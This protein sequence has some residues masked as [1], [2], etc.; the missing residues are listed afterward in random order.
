MHDTHGYLLQPFHDV[1]ASSE[2][3]RKCSS[4]DD[5]DDNLE[6]DASSQRPGCSICLKSYTDDDEVVLSNNPSCRH[7][8]HKECIVPWLAKKED[9]KCPLCREQFIMDCT[10]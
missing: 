3:P 6:A 7:V 9:A 8:F 1:G 4:D 10:V 5:D 2:C